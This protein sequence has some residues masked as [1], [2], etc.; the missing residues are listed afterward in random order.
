MTK[1]RI[2]LVINPYAGMGGRLGLKGTDGDAASI[3]LSRGAEK[4]A[5]VRARVTLEEL[6]RLGKA[7]AFSSEKIAF[8]TCAGEMGESALLGLD[9]NAQVVYQPF[10]S[11]DAVRTSADDTKRACESIVEKGADLL[12]F[13]GGDGTARDVLSV[14]GEKIPMLGI[15][16][17]VKMHSAVFALT[18]ISAS[19]A[20]LKFISG[21]YELAKAEIVDIDE[22]KF[23]KGVFDV[24]LYGY[25]MTIKEPKCVQCAK[26][27]FESESD[28]DDKLAIA[29][30]FI[31]EM[32]E[33][34]GLWILGPGTTTEAIAREAGLGKTLLGVDV[35]Y[36][37]GKKIS[38]L[39]ADV[40]EATLLK[41][42]EGNDAGGAHIVVSPIGKQGFVFGRG[43]QQI[44]ASVISKVGA[45]NVIIVSTKD[46]L[47]KTEALRV[48]TG[49]E[50]LDRELR[51]YKKIVCGYRRSLLKRIE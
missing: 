5:W 27:I 18:P 48:D 3:A 40:D 4:R 44:S 50:A 47:Y 29:A 51:G 1:N 46:K 41:L 17:G 2:G 39:A 14:V 32:R 22:E 45:G 15:P 8:L 42:L 25:C 34:R 23:R 35:L 49:V 26:G 37:D 12:L 9:F 6:S 20:I 36:S 21:N 28:E 30:Y 11:G 7:H 43:N 31:E 10:D 33:K 19:Q 13:C 16:A 24:R 38:M